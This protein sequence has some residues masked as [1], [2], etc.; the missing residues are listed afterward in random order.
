MVNLRQLIDFLVFGRHRLESVEMLPLGSS[1]SDAINL[2]GEPLEAG[3]SEEAPEITQYTFS[4]SVYHEAVIL[5]WEQK[6]QSITYWSVKSDPA[7]DLQ[8]MLDRYKGNSQW[9]VVE[10]GYWYQR[11]DGKLRFWCSAIPA[12]GVAYVDFLVARKTLTT[13]NSV[14][15]LQEL[16]DV[17]WAP[18]DAI[19]ELQR[20]FVEEQ[21]AALSDFARRSKR[22]AVSPDGKHVF[23]VRDH[24]AYD[25][26]DGF[27]ELNRPPNPGVGYST[28]VINC[29]TRSENGS[30]WGKITL[31]RDANV[32]CI[33][34]EEGQ[35]F[36]HIRRLTTNRVLTFRGP[37]ESIRH[38]GR[39]S[40]TVPPFKDDNLW[41][42]LEEE[43]APSGDLPS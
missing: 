6:V 10:E 27:M 9:H 32:D 38:L 22:I 8:C 4:I 39:I 41:K 5:D 43:A 19:F 15:Q 14:K 28:Q 25:V 24:Y 34:F 30:S 16:A 23:V 7:R 17:T 18:D 1:I 11:E 26:P 35:C 3:P 37:P 2:Y 31:P 13:A 21:N 12:I 29:F 42:A 40:I 20:L 33:R 36:C